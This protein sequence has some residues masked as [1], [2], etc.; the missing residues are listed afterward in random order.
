MGNT[1]INLKNLL[2]IYDCIPLSS[3]ECERYFS[4][5]NLIKTDIRNRLEP[6]TIDALMNI[7]LNGKLQNEIT[8]SDLIGMIDQWATNRK[9]YFLKYKK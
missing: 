6:E 7:S 1:C 8:K 2:E 9:R 4:K 3:V 5:F